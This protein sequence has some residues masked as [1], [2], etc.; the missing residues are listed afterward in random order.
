MTSYAS[1]LVFKI[2]K[3]L[4]CILSKYIMP[5]LYF[6]K[7]CLGKSQL[8]QEFLVR[9]EEY[10]GVFLK[11]QSLLYIAGHQMIRYKN[12]HISSRDKYPLTYLNHVKTKNRQY[13]SIFLHMI[14]AVDL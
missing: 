9:Q 13:Q 1:V 2:V 3:S 11:M 14:K 7:Q 5:L 4:H 12:I 6:H 10:K 8:S